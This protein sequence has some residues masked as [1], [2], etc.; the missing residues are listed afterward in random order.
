MQ[1]LL[2]IKTDTLTLSTL[3]FVF[4]K[5]FSLKIGSE[6]TFPSQFQYTSLG[7]GTTGEGGN[8]ER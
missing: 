7:G 3:S 4:S 1:E 6:F 2:E 5:K 8:R